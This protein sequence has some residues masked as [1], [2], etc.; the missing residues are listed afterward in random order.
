MNYINKS[1]YQDKIKFY[2]LALKPL[3]KNAHIVVNYRIKGQYVNVGV[4][5]LNCSCKNVG[6][7][8][9]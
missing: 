7:H 1:M 5:N 8:K 3:N 9:K 6:I 2:D 4:I